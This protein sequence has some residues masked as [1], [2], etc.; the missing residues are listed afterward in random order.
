MFYCR[1]GI[2]KDMFCI[3]Y[4]DIKCFGRTYLLLKKTTSFKIISSFSTQLNLWFQ[5]VQELLNFL[6]NW[7]PDYLNWY[8]LYV[9]SSFVKHWLNRSNLYIFSHRSNY[10]PLYSRNYIIK[11]YNCII[12]A[13]I[14]NITKTQQPFV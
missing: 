13:F 14:W 9:L 12:F 7:S 4:C 5:C 1:V 3:I 10:L 6:I 11:I 8:V 2:L